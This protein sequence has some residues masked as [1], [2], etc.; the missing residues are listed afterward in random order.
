MKQLSVFLENKPGELTA[1][2]DILRDSDISIDSVVIA[3]TSKFGVVRIITSEFDKAADALKKAGFSARTVD[4]VAV[5]IANKKG[6]FAKIVEALSGAGISI[7]YCY[8]YYAD[9]NFGIFVFSLDDN[10]KGQNA[11]SKAGFEIIF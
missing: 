3:E 8:S 4:V 6:T 10:E 2:S 1:M 9:T 11:L 5:K 7:N